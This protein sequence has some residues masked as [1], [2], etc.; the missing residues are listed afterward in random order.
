MLLS[1]DGNHGAIG[2]IVVNDLL[3]AG[4]GVTA[5]ARNPAKV[6]P[7]WAE[8]NVQ[9][10]VVEIIDAAAVD[11]AVAGADAVVSALGPSMDRMTTGLPLVEGTRLIID[12]M[13]RHEVRRF[14]GNGTPS[15]V[16]DRDKPNLQQKT[17]GFMGRTLLPRAYRELLA[18]MRGLSRSATARATW[19]TPSV[20]IRLRASGVGSIALRTARSIPEQKAP[21]APVSTI[22]LT[23]SSAAAVRSASAQA[24]IIS[25]VNAFLTA[26]RL[27][28]IVSIASSTS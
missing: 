6:P 1:R 7:S 4:H 5:Y 27:S 10:I 3:R 16:D 22:T 18:A 12:A 2:Q 14:V 23:A 19:C 15:I 25:K 20:S 13:Q 8:K 11:R 26:G 21:P 9:V 17:I 24:S 28:V